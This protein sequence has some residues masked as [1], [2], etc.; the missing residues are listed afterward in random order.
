MQGAGG[1]GGLLSVT[2][3]SGANAGTYFYCYDGNGNVVVLVNAADGSIAAR[4][5]YGPFG[6]LLRATGLMAKVN[7]FRFSTKYQ[8]DE[9]GLLYYGYRYYDPSTGSWLSRDPIEEQGGLQLVTSRSRKP[10]YAVEDKQL[11]AF[12]SNDP[13][14][15]VD[16]LGLYTAKVGNC[17]IVVL[18]GHGSDVTHH[19]FT[20][21][22]TKCSVASFVGCYSKTTN[23]KIAVGNQ[24]PG[25]PSTDEE[26]YTGPRANDDPDHSFYKYF[27]NTW[28]AA[29]M[30]A[31]AMCR[32]CCC[33]K[34][35]IRSELAGSWWNSDNW[36]F[37]GTK[38]EVVSCSSIGGS[39]GSTNSP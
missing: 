34:V 18:Y 11:Y 7:P 14:N 37:P 8:D 39:A 4:Y 33:A 9:T 24:I 5:E 20:F 29:K 25:A 36:G 23:D 15:R 10:P 27:D 2:V 1:V 6:E 28:A 21:A 12:V 22:T 38:K 32:R 16:V 35:T 17:E 3:H 19:S 30:E 26:T 13:L 31:A